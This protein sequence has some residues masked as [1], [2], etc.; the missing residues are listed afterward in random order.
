MAKIRNISLLI[1]GKSNELQLHYRPANTRLY[2][3][4]KGAFYVKAAGELLEFMQVLDV[5]QEQLEAETEEAAMKKAK[6]LVK[7]IESEKVE[8]EKIIA[9]RFRGSS[10]DLNRPRYVGRSRDAEVTIEFEYKLLLRRT[11]NKKSSLFIQDFNDPKKP[12]ILD[13]YTSFGDDNDD[14]KEIP[15]TKEAE[16]FMKKFYGSLEGL[17]KAFEKFLLPPKLMLAAIQA[18]QGL[19]LEFKGGKP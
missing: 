17:I 1:N 6:D 5:S 18:G 15:W 19:A 13:H 3:N 4:A 12:W 8:E 2:S 9:Y 10:A 7:R 16:A 11:L 14:W